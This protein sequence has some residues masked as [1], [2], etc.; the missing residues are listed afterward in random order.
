MTDR[1]VRG[2]GVSPGVGLGQAV[3]A[4]FDVPDVPNRFIGDEDAEAE[5]TRLQLAV[6]GVVEVLGALRDRVRERAG[7]EE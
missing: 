6:T 4:R 1:V 3:I 2:I 5:L 7:V